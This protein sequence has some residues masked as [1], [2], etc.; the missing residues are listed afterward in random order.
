LAAALGQEA[1]PDQRA[2][3]LETGGGFRRLHRG[4]GLRVEVPFSGRLR[5]G[6][7]HC[8]SAGDRKRGA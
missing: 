8:E 5:Q 3:E 7:A 4:L 1:G 6:A 2:G